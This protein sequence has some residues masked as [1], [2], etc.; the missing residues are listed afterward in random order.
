MTSTSTSPLPSF[1]PV[2]AFPMIAPCAFA[3][4]APDP[5][6]ADVTGYGLSSAMPAVPHLIS[7]SFLPLTDDAGW[8]PGF[9]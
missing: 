3:A 4:S 2:I 5:R 9:R 8:I 6:R 1:N 7:V